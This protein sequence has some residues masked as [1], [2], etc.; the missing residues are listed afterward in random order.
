MNALRLL[1][2]LGLALA[3]RGVALAGEAV[4]VLPFENLSGVEE[5]QGVVAPL[6]AGELKRRGY[7]IVPGE[8]VAAALEAGRVRFLDSISAAERGRLL[9]ALHAD[10]LLLGAIYTWA[11][12]EDP[13][14]ALSFR[15]LD[16]EGRT[17]WGH[18]RALSG[19]ASEG[20][21]GLGRGRNP[22]QLAS[23]VVHGL[24]SDL[25]RPG[26]RV[27]PSGAGRPLFL[28]SARTYVSTALPKS[29]ARIAILP[30]ESASPVRE[31]P[32]V[33][34]SLLARRLAATGRFDVVEDADVRAA[35]VAAKVRG[36]RG[37]D[38]EALRALGE[39]LGTSLFLTGAIWTWRDG[40]PRAANGWA[41]ADF[42]LTLVDVAAGRV[43]WTSR[44]A[45]KGEDYRGL[46]E[47][48]AVKSVVA[49]ADRMFGEMVAS[50]KSTTP[51][52]SPTHMKILHP[53]GGP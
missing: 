51:K 12:G 48:G 13:V 29:G 33:A 7:E 18:A 39:K 24:F 28:A 53:K 11:E 25:P 10:A 1:A 46:F 20:L 17:A 8:P 44:L 42:G 6:V 14:V 36:I 35:L 26:G 34:G 50:E 52:T 4:A 2:L 27:K 30:L 32:R 5:A 41:E 15:L 3:W 9:P 38:P 43:L 19:E 40:T 31:A 45:R 16:A 37:A 23:R 49:L 47:R 21:L 22:A